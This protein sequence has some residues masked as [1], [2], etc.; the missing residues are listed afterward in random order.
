L[1]LFDKF[2]TFLS[3]NFAL[4]KYKDL[5]AIETHMNTILNESHVYFNELNLMEKNISRSIASNWKDK[6]TDIKQNKNDY[7]DKNNV[8]VLLGPKITFNDDLENE[9]DFT[10]VIENNMKIPVYNI[11]IQINID[12]PLHPLDDNY[13][14]FSILPNDYDRL[15]YQPDHYFTVQNYQVNLKMSYSHWFSNN[16]ENESCF[17]Y[18]TIE[19]T[20]T[21]SINPYYY[22]EQIETDLCLKSERI[23]DVLNIIEN[24]LDKGNE[25]IHIFGLK[26]S[27]K[28]SLIKCMTTQKTIDSVYFV[29]MMSRN[30][31]NDPCERIRYDLARDAEF[32]KAQI[33]SSRSPIAQNDKQDSMLL[34]QSD[35]HVITSFI[36]YLKENNK[37]L[38]YIIDDIHEISTACLYDIA[39]SARDLGFNLIF[40]SDWFDIYRPNNYD[41]FPMPL[42]SFDYHELYE[43]INMSIPV[44][45]YSDQAMSYL[46]NLTG[47]H[48]QLLFIL[49]NHLHYNCTNKRDYNINLKTIQQAVNKELLHDPQ[50]FT[51]FHEIFTGI[52][53]KHQDFL[54]SLVVNNII[55]P[56]TLSIKDNLEEQNHFLNDLKNMQI[57]KQNHSRW[58]LNIG[59]FKLWIEANKITPEKNLLKNNKIY[60]NEIM[61]SK[62]HDVMFSYNLK[63]IEE[64]RQFKIKLEREKF[65]VFMAPEGIRTG[66]E[67]RKSIDKKIETCTICMIIVSTNLISEKYMFE[68]I[69]K[70]ID[71][72]KEKIFPVIISKLSDNQ[73]KRL[74]D[75]LYRYNLSR[76]QI[77]D[78]YS[79]SGAFDKVVEDMKVMISNH[80][81]ND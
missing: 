9:F 18:N 26:G 36:N 80:N 77:A 48:P 56:N 44:L 12:V 65:S 58:K 34:Q 13:T 19:T 63:D 24:K 53:Q 2:Y 39:C 52:P 43:L 75:D 49:F 27:G 11:S 29:K 28:S 73:R 5:N 21:E 3:D 62:N 72:Y 4:T 71:K 50:K 70:I 45:N 22:L 25:I 6:I 47:G 38:V 66:A 76:F 16:N 41:K 51:L 7:F 74:E 61:I 81:T 33:D 55:C 64:V 37:K 17:R 59:F 10:F 57:I 67:W 8:S 31:F 79:D 35:R 14:I 1:T 60:Q 32:L 20:K 46:K 42:I 15:L 30:E 68:E 40:I 78:I 23:I 69:I 54:A